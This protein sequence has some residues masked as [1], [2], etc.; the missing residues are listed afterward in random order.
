MKDLKE[1]KRLFKKYEI[2]V[3]YYI[4]KDGITTI[5]LERFG[6]SLK[7]EEEELKKHHT[8]KAARFVLKAFKQ[9]PK[10]KDAIDEHIKKLKSDNGVK[11][12]T[13]IKETVIKPTIVT[14]DDKKKRIRKFLMEE[15]IL[16]N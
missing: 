7:F 1:L 13:T 9:H 2:I 11:T 3:K 15:G 8:K 5:V 4:I 16:T 6:M 12:D 10:Y 14:I